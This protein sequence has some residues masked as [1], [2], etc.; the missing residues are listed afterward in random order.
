MDMDNNKSRSWG[1]LRVVTTLK[2]IGISLF[3]LCVLLRNV[4]FTSIDSREDHTISNK[5][6]MEI[7]STTP[8]EKIVLLGE[9]HSGTNWIT[10]H[11]TACFQ[12]D[13]IKV[14]NVHLTLSSA[15]VASS[16]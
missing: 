5:N 16:H 10:D 4:Q 2:S 3:L 11:L 8:V 9:R 1:R 6:V 13:H 7:L 12:D 14:C 15:S